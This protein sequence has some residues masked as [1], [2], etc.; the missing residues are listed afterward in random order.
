M[1]NKITN[2]LGMAAK[3]AVSKDDE[4]S[5]LLGA[6]GIRNDG[7][8]VKAMNSP[9]Q[10][11]DKM[12][13]AESKLTR[14]LGFGADV[15]VSRIAKGSREWAMAKPCPFCQCILKAFRVY[16]VYYTIDKQFYGIWTPSSDT[17]KVIFFGKE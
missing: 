5:F 17:D 3:I 7:A 1:K 9:S 10:L 16:K 15:F 12:A 8:I 13:H 14:K 4:R 6:I 2:Y 11:Q